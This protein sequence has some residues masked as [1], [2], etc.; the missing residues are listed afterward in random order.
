MWILHA[1]SIKVCP[2]W[3]AP[4]I[5]FATHEKCYEKIAI[6]A[7]V[8]LGL[9]EVKKAKLKIKDKIKDTTEKKTNKNLRLKI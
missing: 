5:V 8:L 7:G 2:F 6:I 3:S 4:Q 9:P 1:R